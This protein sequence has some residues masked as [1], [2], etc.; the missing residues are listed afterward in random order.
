MG[1]SIRPGRKLLAILAAVLLCVLPAAE[2]RGAQGGGRLSSELEEKVRASGADDLLPVIIQTVADPTSGHFARLH[3]RGGAV[4]SSH[5]SIRGYSA[6]VPASQLADLAGQVQ[7]G[8][9]CSF[10]PAKSI[11][12][13]QLIGRLQ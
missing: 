9:P 1:C 11:E 12:Q 7:V 6:R 8:L 2:T 13:L 10:K 4:K 3:G 5:L